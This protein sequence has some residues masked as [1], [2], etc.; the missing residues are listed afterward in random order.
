LRRVDLD[1]I[2]IGDDRLLTGAR[3]VAQGFRL[4]SEPLDRSCHIFRLGQKGIPQVGGPVYILGH[5]IKDGW[6]VG[7]CLDAFVPVL[8]INPRHISAVLQPRCRVG[9]L[10]RIR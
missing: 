4:P 2:S 7:N 1:I 8:V 6:I 5:H 9:N 10:S 3:Q